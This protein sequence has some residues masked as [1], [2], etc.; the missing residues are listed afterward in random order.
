MKNAIFNIIFIVFAPVA[1]AMTFVI[2]FSY[3]ASWGLG[4]SYLDMVGSTLTIIMGFLVWIACTIYFIQ[5]VIDQ[6]EEDKVYKEE[7]REHALNSGMDIITSEE[8]NDLLE[9]Q[10]ISVLQTACLND[11][12]VT[13]VRTNSGDLKTVVVL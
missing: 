5:V 3:A 12:V 7:Q 4:F 6:S 2:S 1:L 13:S 11:L 8:M 10:K 9:Q